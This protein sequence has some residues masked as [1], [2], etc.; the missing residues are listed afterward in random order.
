M[1][2]T[3]SARASDDGNTQP[4]LSSGSTHYASDYY[5]VIA[6]TSG[7]GNVK[8]IRCSN[9]AGV[10]VTVKVYVNGGSARHPRAHGA[11]FMADDVRRRRVH[12][13]LGTRL[14]G[15]NHRR[16]G[17]ELPDRHPVL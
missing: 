15:R 12:R 16:S 13:E 8:D 1:T 4:R 2:F 9:T 3:P 5:E 6:T 14:T 17:T 10:A 7:A 11:S